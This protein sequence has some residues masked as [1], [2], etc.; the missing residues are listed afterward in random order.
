MIG[1]E[2]IKKLKREGFKV[3]K[4]SKGSHYHMTKGD[5]YVIVPH[6]HTELGKGLYSR[7]LEDAM[8]K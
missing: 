4:V 7:I 5:A 1:V 2:M 8:L 6:H 3:V